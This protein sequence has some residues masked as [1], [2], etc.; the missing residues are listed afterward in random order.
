MATT[1]RGSQEQAS[2]EI[3][4]DQITLKF[5]VVG[6]SNHFMMW[7]IKLLLYGHVLCHCLLSDYF[8]S[9]NYN[10]ENDHL[11]T[12]YR[13]F[14]KKQSSYLMRLSLLESDSR[15]TCSLM[16]SISSQRSI[17]SSSGA[18]GSYIL[19]S[20]FLKSAFTSVWSQYPF[21]SKSE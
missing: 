5:Q 13:K 1:L 17:M 4:S 3:R 2:K 12:N 11:I 8:Y 20:S 15:K 9:F 10:H 6:C 14:S 18:L 16:R 21:P 7:K 19:S